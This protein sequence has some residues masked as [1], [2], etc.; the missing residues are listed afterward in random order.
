VNILGAEGCPYAEMAKALLG[1]ELSKFPSVFHPDSTY[2]S[3]S[4]MQEFRGM[5]SQ[6]Q[7]S[8]C[9]YMDDKRIGGYTELEKFTE[10]I[11]HD[12]MPQQTLANTMQNDR[13]YTQREPTYTK[14][15]EKDRMPTQEKLTEKQEQPTYTKTPYTTTSH[16]DHMST[17]R[18]Q[19]TKTQRNDRMLGAFV[20]TYRESNDRILLV[21]MKKK[22]YHCEKLK[23]DMHW[24]QDVPTLYTTKKKVLL[25]VTLSEDWSDQFSS[26]ILKH[27]GAEISGYPAVLEYDRNNEKWKAHKK[28]DM[29]YGNDWSND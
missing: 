1:D 19:F 7:T 29:L 6:Q 17:K 12:Q 15:L 23:S 2:T 11:Q 18:K 9:V 5:T 28:R 26:D 13:M 27:D 21:I 3:V 24:D 4:T 20:D 25:A 10:T 22:C 8:P 16:T 14:K